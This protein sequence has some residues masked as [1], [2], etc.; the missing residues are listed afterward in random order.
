MDTAYGGEY[1]PS[2]AAT[3]LSNPQTQIYKQLAGI[4]V[5]NPVMNAGGGQNLTIAVDIFFWHGLVSYENYFAY[6]ANNCNDNQN[7]GIC[8]NI[9]N[10]M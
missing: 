9:W 4:M 6:N 2:L 1:V 10:S 3:I 7:S 8:G 5:G